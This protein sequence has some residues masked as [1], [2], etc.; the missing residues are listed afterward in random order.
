[1][2]HPELSDTADG[3]VNGTITLEN[4]WAVATKVENIHNTINSILGI[5]PPEMHAQ[6]HKKTCTILEC[7]RQKYPVA[8]DWKLPKHPIGNTVDKYIVVYS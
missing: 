3:P 2:K 1:M 7:S 5:Y 4:C 6:V 8:P